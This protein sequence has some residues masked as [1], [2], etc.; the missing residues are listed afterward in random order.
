VR[1]TLLSI[2]AVAILLGAAS[3]GFAQGE[4]KPIATVSFAGYDRLKADI[5]VIGRLVGNPKLADML[6]MMLKGKTQGKGLTGLDTK[7]PWGVAFSARPGN[8]RIC[9]T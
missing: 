9:R 2:L 5:G 7:R 4:M 6:E 1:K 3:F 8:A